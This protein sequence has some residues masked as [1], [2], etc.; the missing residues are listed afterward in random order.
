MNFTIIC[1]HKNEN[2]LLNIQ[3]Y[4]EFSV[5][6]DIG[7][8]LATTTTDSRGHFV[9]EGNTANFQGIFPL[10]KTTNT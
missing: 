3:F 9:I 10:L 8:A 4:D 6:S 2:I 5:N 7:Q 1:G